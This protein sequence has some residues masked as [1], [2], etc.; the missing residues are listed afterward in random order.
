MNIY[1]ICLCHMTVYSSEARY[2]KALGSIQTPWF[3]KR[4]KNQILL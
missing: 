2:S 1:G 3:L 4:D